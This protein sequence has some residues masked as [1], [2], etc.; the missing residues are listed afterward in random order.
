MQLDE[1]AIVSTEQALLNNIDIV[2]SGTA[3]ES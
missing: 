3:L 1:G 2:F